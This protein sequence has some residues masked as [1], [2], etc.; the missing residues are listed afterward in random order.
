MSALVPTVLPA[1]TQYPDLTRKLAEVA[2]QTLVTKAQQ[3]LERGAI[4]NA[5][6]REVLVEKQLANAATRQRMDAQATAA[7]PDVEAL[8][9]EVAQIRAALATVQAER[10]RALA[11]L[12]GALAK[13]ADDA[14]ATRL[15]VDEFVK[16]VRRTKEG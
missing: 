1:V 6:A 16:L 7:T 5:T 8:T 12:A 11:L 10:D 14:A 9:R 4:E 13:S 15:A 2:V 3:Q